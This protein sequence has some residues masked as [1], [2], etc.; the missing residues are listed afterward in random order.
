MRGNYDRSATLS[1][2]DKSTKIS[3]ERGEER[4]RKLDLRGLAPRETLAFEQAL[5]A[6][7][8]RNVELGQEG[9]MP[10]TAG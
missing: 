4:I 7:D 6:G 9:A 3:R 5:L 2:T 1:E 10:W 8:Q